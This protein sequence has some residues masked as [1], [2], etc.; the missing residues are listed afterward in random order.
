VVEVFNW[1]NTGAEM[2]AVMGRAVQ[3]LVRKGGD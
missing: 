1:T 2:E 3:R